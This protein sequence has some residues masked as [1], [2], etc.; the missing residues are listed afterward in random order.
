VGSAHAAVGD[1]L[2]RLAEGEA[3]VP[4]HVRLVDAAER[5]VRILV[6]DE[7]LDLVPGVPVAAGER[8]TAGA[9][10]GAGGSTVGGRLTHDVER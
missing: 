9:G 6:G 8:L 1:G 10:A 7:M 4:W 2:A 3:L 5:G